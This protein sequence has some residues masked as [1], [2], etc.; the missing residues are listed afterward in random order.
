MNNFL[1]VGRKLQ[2]FRGVGFVSYGAVCHPDVFPAVDVRFESLPAIRAHV[3]PRVRMGAHM[4]LEGAV[5][6]ELGAANRAR[7]VLKAF[8]RNKEN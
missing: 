1:H 3:R 7:I 5:G 6:G 4:T 8:K 2:L